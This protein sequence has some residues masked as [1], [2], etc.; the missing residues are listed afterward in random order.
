[1]RLTITL[2]LMA[3][4]AVG[5]SQSFFDDF[6]RADGGLGANYTAVTGAMQILGNEATGTA[7]GNGLTLVNAG[8]FS[9]AYSVHRVQ[10]DVRVTDQ[11]STL[12]YVALALG[13]NGVAAVNNGIFVKLQRQVAGGFSHIGIYTGAGSS[14]TGITTSGGAFQAIATPFSAARFTVEVTSATTL[15]TGIDTNFDNVDDI[16]YNST[17][18]IGTLTVG[19]RVGLHAYG[20]LGRIDNYRATAVPEPAT[21]AALGLGVA[22]MIRRRRRS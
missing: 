18:N 3:L 8:L 20:T 22:A 11:S 9:A 6:N 21:M 4:A 19:N 12:A 1:M 17:L 7:N 5:L 15:Y 14:G 10:A 13:H 16:V 2:G